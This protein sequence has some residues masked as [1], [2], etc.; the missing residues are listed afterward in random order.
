MTVGEF[1]DSIR[2]VNIVP[3]FVM[4]AVILGMSL[5]GGV[6]LWWTDP[7]RRRKR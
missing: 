3:L 1:L 5:M 2:D 4:C 7:H 6:V